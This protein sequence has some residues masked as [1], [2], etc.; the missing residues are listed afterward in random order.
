MYS[1]YQMYLYPEHPIY[2]IVGGVLTA[3]S[4]IA[5]EAKEEAEKAES[6]VV[7]VTSE[8]KNLGDKILSTVS[9]EYLS[10]AASKTW[11]E[12]FET[13]LNQTSTDFNFSVSQLESDLQD[14]IDTVQNKVNQNMTDIQTWMRFDINGLTIGKT[15]D[16]FTLRITNN[17]L[18]FYSDDIE[19]AYM[20]DN[21]LY[22]TQAQFST[23]M[24][25]GDFAFEPQPN[26]NMSV[27]Y[28][29]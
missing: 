28:V 23:R 17:K 8:I 14:K 12:T 15:G 16:K 2:R 6:E 26:K 18:S 11:T 13:R 9:E 3:A 25:L 27:V 22:I 29:G 24:Q 10:K 19:I 5:Y 1:T 7:S 21:K 20:S 4:Q